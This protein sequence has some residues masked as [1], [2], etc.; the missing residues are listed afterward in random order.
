MRTGLHAA[1]VLVGCFLV[2]CAPPAGRSRITADQ[3]M[4][5]QYGSGSDHG[6]IG[7]EE[8]GRITDAYRRNIAAPRRDAD[9]ATSISDTR[10]TSSGQN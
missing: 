9:A 5:F 3:V 7:G 8:A 6:A 2:A 1:S 10:P 4:T